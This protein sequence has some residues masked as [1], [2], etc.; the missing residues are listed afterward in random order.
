MLKNSI[1][2][3]VKN[4]LKQEEVLGDGPMNRIFIY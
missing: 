1:D 2:K 4:G 3:I